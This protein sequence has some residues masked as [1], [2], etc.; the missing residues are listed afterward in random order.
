MYLGLAAAAGALTGGLSG[1]EARSDGPSPRER[2]RDE[3]LPNVPLVTHEGRTVRFYDDLVKDRLVVL[4]FMYTRCA[5]GTC[6]ITSANLARVQKLLG[7]GRMGHDIF[8]LSIT[9]TPDHDTPPVLKHYARAHGAGPGWI[10]LT[11]KE[12][13]IELLRRK[14]GFTDLDPKLDADKASHIGTIRYGNEPLQLWAACP[15]NASA[16]YIAQQISWLDWPT[17]ARAAR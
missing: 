13:D 5:D 8:F 1:R 10:F 17:P 11:G 3:H 14:L 6:P 12:Q 4:N 7:H 9:L 16:T 15:G 2:I